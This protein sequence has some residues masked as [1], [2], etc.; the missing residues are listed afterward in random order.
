MRRLAMTTYSVTP[1]NKIEIDFHGV[2]PSAD[3]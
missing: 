1:E 3:I 2:K